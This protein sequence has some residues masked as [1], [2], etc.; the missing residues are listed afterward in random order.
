MRNARNRRQFLP[1]GV[2]R[3]FRLLPR[4]LG[5][6]KEDLGLQDFGLRPLK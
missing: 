2:H 4:Q 6:L 5:L 1:G 3:D